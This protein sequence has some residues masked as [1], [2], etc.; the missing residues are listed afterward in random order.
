MKPFHAIP[1]CLLMLHVSTAHAQED[2]LKMKIRLL[3]EAE[4]PD[5]R[6]PV[7]VFPLGRTV[8]VLRSTQS[9]DPVQSYSKQMPRFELY[10]RTKLTLLRGQ[11]PVLKVKAGELFLE[12]LALFGGEP[13]MIAMRRDT[14][15]GV[16]E[17]YWQRVDPNLT[18]PHGLFEKLCAFD[19]RTWGSGA[20][21]SSGQGYR[22]RFETSLSPDGKHMVI[23]SQGITAG[24]GD[25][26][27]PFAMVGPGMELLW[28]HTPEIEGKAPLVGMQATNDGTA[29]LLERHRFTPADPKK[30]ST[31]FRLKLFRADKEDIEEVE[32][33]L[34]KDRHVKSAV[35]RPLDDGR[36]A[37]AGLFGGLN[38]KGERIIG[39]FLGM[40]PPG[41]D[42]MQV[43]Y[44]R[45]FKMETDDASYTNGSMRIV[46]V[47]PRGDGGFYMLRE[48][49]LETDKVDAKTAMSGLRWIHGPLVITNVDKDGKEAWSTVFRR[50]FYSPD[51]MVHEPIALVY[52]GKFMLFM[53]DND[54]QMEKRKKDDRKLLHTDTK[55][56][57]STY[58]LFNEQGGFKSKAIL[59]GKEGT[60]YLL[61]DRF[62]PMAPND[63]VGVGSIRMNGKNPQLL[64]L[65]L[66]Q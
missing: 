51:R 31:T 24:D 62:W 4:S 61:G 66:G 42:K 3:P 60:E 2:K 54:Q 20:K 18:K 38:P 28:Y 32:F 15:Q 17:L 19:T 59:Q 11:D 52:E 25:L 26:M 35:L 40:F 12:Q 63:H 57:Y 44:Q 23:Y 56:P 6:P 36:I 13:V 14:V 48:Y 50:L 21:V 34:D 64:R 49:H 29:W 43:V 27:R 16:V 9:S 37:C 46:D 53:L 7:N 39:E 8:M 58:V 1:C 41:A 30:D 55:S 33:G 10:D 65:E 47:L 22:D 45:V 5:K